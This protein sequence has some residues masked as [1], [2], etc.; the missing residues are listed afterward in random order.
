MTDDGRPVLLAVMIFP[1]D[2]LR[3]SKVLE[4]AELVYRHYGFEKMYM[5]ATRLDEGMLIKGIERS[6]I[7]ERLGKPPNVMFVLNQAAQP[8]PRMKVGQ[9]FHVVLQ[10]IVTLFLRQCTPTVSMEAPG[11]FS[12]YQNCRPER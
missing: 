8:A 7:Q 10:F 1:L 6:K 5:T 9:G 12:N 11:G 3:E 2:K 4:A